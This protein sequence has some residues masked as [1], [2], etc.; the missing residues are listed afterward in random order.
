[1]GEGLGG[2][3]VPAPAGNGD[4]IGE[5]CHLRKEKEFFPYTL[6]TNFQSFVLSARNPSTAL[7]IIEHYLFIFNYYY[8]FLVLP[9]YCY[10]PISLHSHAHMLSH[11][12]PWT[13][14][15]QAPLSMDFSRQE[16][17]SGLP[18]PSPIEHHILKNQFGGRL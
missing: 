15:H 13:S 12:I 3:R 14:V 9:L 6:L 11:V 16:Y 4:E 8:F 10:Q 17:W 2:G 5:T 1:M 18:F 7:N